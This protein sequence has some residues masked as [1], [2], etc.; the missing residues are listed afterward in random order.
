MNWIKLCNLL[1]LIC[2]GC[3]KKPPPVPVPVESSPQ[4]VS[5]PSV[6]EPEPLQSMGIRDVI[7]PVQWP[8]TVYFEFDA[9][10]SS[11]VTG[12]SFNHL[13]KCVEVV[14]EGHAC[15]IGPSEYNQGLSERRADFVE[16]Y[17]KL[18]GHTGQTK[19]V[20]YGESRPIEGHSNELQRRAEIYCKEMH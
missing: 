13:E 18:N 17:L 8:M 19:T 9:D 2:W 4:E 10:Y 20:G 3:A 12:I 11:D 15:P 14:I 6:E 1:A 16:N 7:K 5:F